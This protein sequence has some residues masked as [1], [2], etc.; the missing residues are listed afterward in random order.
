MKNNI[1]I[2]V[3][4]TIVALGVIVTVITASVLN[5]SGTSSSDSSPQSEYSPG[6]FDTFETSD[7][8]ETSE[9]FDSSDASS[10]FSGGSSGEQP[11]DVST[12]DI[13]S[14]GGI[15]EIADAII[16]TA[17]SLIG[18]PFEENGSSPEGFD[19]SGFIYYVLRENGY[20]TCPRG[21]EAQSNMGTRLDYDSVKAGDLVFFCNE[22]SS[23]AGFGGIYVGGGK[24]IA[25]LMPGTL[26]G[27]V[28]ISTS[29]YKGSFYGGVSLS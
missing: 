28:D 20:I 18:V 9:R 6:G 23:S 26:V 2:I 25:C 7:T 22:G 16:A 3:I 19:N 12:S 4:V 1:L 5:G 15:S 11:P 13:S 21:T 29:Y 8:S 10:D 14:S 17:S 24:M 27:E